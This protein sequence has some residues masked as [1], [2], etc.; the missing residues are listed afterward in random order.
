M[1]RS[2]G[3]HDFVARWPVHIGYIAAIAIIVLIIAGGVALEPFASS[4]Q[5][6]LLGDRSQLVKA[7]AYE[8]ANGDSLAEVERRLGLWHHKKKKTWI[9]IQIKGAHSPGFL[10]QYPQGIDP[11]DEFVAY[12]GNFQIVLQFRNGKLINHNRDWLLRLAN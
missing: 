9:E 10:K 12:H 8:I 5:F 1:T 2:A 3:G 6:R 11:D 4:T 7:L